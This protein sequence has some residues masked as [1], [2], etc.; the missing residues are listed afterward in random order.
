MS[1][2][3]SF[4][5][6]TS[7]PIV[8]IVNGGSEQS[9]INVDH[10]ET[11]EF[12]YMQQMN[13]V[14]DLAIPAPEPIS[15]L[16]IGGCGCALAWAWEVLRPGSRQLAIEVDADLVTAVRERLPL[17]RKPLLRLRAAEG[18]A[19]LAAS[20]AQYQVIVRDAFTDSEVPA[21]LQTVEWCNLVAQH[22][23][24]GGIYLA[25]VAH[26]GASQWPC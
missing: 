21:H 24:P 5:F 8:S 15:A 25:N 20:K 14:M 10:P 2:T 18:A 26:G 3:G 7:G 23:R 17:P 11:L 16:H 1:E 13:E 12:E 19:A 4:T 9:R 6:V 22:L